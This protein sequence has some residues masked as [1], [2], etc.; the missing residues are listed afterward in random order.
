[1]KIVYLISMV[2]LNSNTPQI[3][4]QVTKFT[5]KHAVENCEAVGKSLENLARSAHLTSV[6]Y[7]CKVVSAD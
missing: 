2:L 7:E 6:L 4:H 3:D 1:M 5:G